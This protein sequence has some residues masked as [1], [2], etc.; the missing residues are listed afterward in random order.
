MKYPVRPILHAIAVLATAGVSH[1]NHGTTNPKG[2]VADAALAGKKHILWYDEP[3]KDWERQALPIGNGRLG[4]MVFGGVFNERIQFNEDSLWIGDELDTGAYQAFGDLYLSLHE[5]DFGPRWLQC[6]SGHRAESGPAEEIGSSVDGK[7]NTKW[8]VH[9]HGRPVQWQVKLDQAAIVNEYTLTS[10][11]DVPGRDPKAWLLEGSPDGRQWTLLDQRKNQPPFEQRKQAKSF[12]FDNSTAYRFYRLT[13]QANHGDDLYQLS[14]ISLNESPVHP[15]DVVTRPPTKNYRR[16]LDINRAVH[17]TSYHFDGVNYKR[18]YFASHPAQVMVFHF[19][20]DKPGA[21]SGKIELTDAH[22]GNIKAVGNKLI[23]NGSLKGYQFEGYGGRHKKD[24]SINLDYEAQAQV[25]HHGGSLTT[26]G[27]SLVFQGCDA[28]TVL[29]AA[30]TNYLNERNKGWK[31]AHPHEELNV[32]LAAASA[33]PYPTLLNEHIEDYQSLF[34]RLQIELGTSPAHSAQMTTDQRLNAYREAK[35][36]TPDHALEELIFQYARYLMIASSRPGG[37]PANLQGLWNDKNSPP[38]RSDYHTDVNVQMNYWFVD[39]ANLSECFT[40][41]SEWLYSTVEVKKEK[42][43]KNFKV[44]GWALRSENGIFGGDSYHY[45]P[46]DAAWLMQNIWDHYAFTLDHD[47]LE[48]RAYPL[49][50]SLCEYWED[51]LIEW[52]DGQLVSPMS[53]SPE[54]GPKAEGNSYEQQLVHNLFGNFIKA[55]EVLGRD[56]E[57]REKIRSMRERLLGPQIG[58]W[59]QLQEWAKDIDDPNNQHRHLSHLIAVH[60]GHQISPLTTPKLAEAARVSM[61]ARGD[62]ATGWSKAWKINIWARLQDGNRAYKL[63]SEQV[64]GKYHPNLL[65]FH[66]PFQIDGHFGYASGVCEMLLQSHTGVVDLLPALPDAWKNGQV[67]GL[68]AHGDY[69]VNLQWKDGNLASADVQAGPKSKGEL[70]LSYKGR[71][72]KIHLKAGDS[73]AISAA[74]F[75]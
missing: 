18:E 22:K 53:I 6:S 54:H 60:P 69:T 4:G 1:A 55:S 47:Y 27:N 74:D 68:K 17:S 56:E 19:T 14:E 29:L 24:Y 5:C 33:K 66:P 8:C 37:L 11:N 3:A 49:L 48:T 23:S 64:K 7:V 63:L 9:H 20:A 13:L 61:N 59:G 46:G 34:N 10:A 26:E 21:Y 57:F 42:T 25:L 12:T 52:P 16:E 50:K 44:R 70:H 62:G 73:I 67:K 39:R 35:A 36:S 75:S 2:D 32:Q 65:C 71:S 40:P 51:S 72:K 15:Q 38:W 41:L 31:K 28:L 30:D 43:N 58:K 45:V